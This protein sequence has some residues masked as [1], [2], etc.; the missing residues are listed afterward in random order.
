MAATAARKAKIREAELI[1]SGL[2]DRKKAIEAEQAKLRLDNK[3]TET[4]KAKARFMLQELAAE[5]AAQ[6]KVIRPRKKP[7]G[8]GF[9]G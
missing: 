8:G 7:A 1:L 2:L 3:M 9:F 5:I 6:R 4:I